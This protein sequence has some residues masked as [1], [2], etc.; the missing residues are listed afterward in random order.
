LSNNQRILKRI[1]F[2]FAIISILMTGNWAIQRKN[3]VTGDEP[4][5]LVMAQ[6]FLRHGSF[7]QTLPYAEEFQERRI[8]GGGLQPGPHVVSGPHGQ[9]NVHNI[10]LPLLLLLPF[11]IGGVAGAK[12]FMIALAMLIPRAAWRLTEDTGLSARQRTLAVVATVFSMPFLPASSQIFPDMVAGIGALSVLTWLILQ[13]DSRNRTDTALAFIAPLLL[14]WLQIK[15]SATAL[16]LSV[17]FFWGLSRDKKTGSQGLKWLFAA[18]F[19]TSIVTL[20]LYNQYAFGNP[21]GPYKSGSLEISPTALMVLLG[22]HIDQN[23]GIMMQNPL[24]LLSLTA[25]IPWVRRNPAVSLLT[26]ACFGSLIV[27]NAMHPVWYGGYS[28]SGRF[29]WAAFI[30]LLALPMWMLTQTARTNPRL[31]QWLCLGAILFQT[32]LFFLYGGLGADMY[33]RPPDTWL[34]SYSMLHGSMGQYLPAAFNLELALKHVPNAIWLLATPML[35]AIGLLQS[36][37]RPKAVIALSA[38]TVVALVA[39]RDFG[40]TAEPSVRTFSAVTLPSATGLLEND[41][42]SAKPGRDKAGHLTFGPYFSMLRGRYKASLSYSATGSSRETIGVFE[43]YDASSKRL[44]QSIDVTGTDGQI[45][46]ISL[47][48]RISGITSSTMEF[49]LYWTGQQDT[50]VKWVSV[51][52]TN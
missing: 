1:L 50:R 39:T 37:Y 22:L 28:F 12:L 25:L 36:A 14:P 30:A 8:Y 42:R 48:F 23:Q 45:N 13:P 31:F 52:T 43:V 5:Y 26:L 41:E 35:L 6:G 3:S 19:A 15:F 29:A 17:G 38:V 27:P 9:F 16:L 32:W 24:Y 40:S 4:H 51:Q 21:S 20:A 33:N 7:E 10:G 47:P 44:L 34:K 2:A 11:A 18:C 49:R 46:T